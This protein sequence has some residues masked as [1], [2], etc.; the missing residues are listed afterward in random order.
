MIFLVCTTIN[1]R[2]N[3]HLILLWIQ[4]ESVLLIVIF[5]PNSFQV[6]ILFFLMISLLEMTGLLK[7]LRNEFII[8]VFSE[9]IASESLV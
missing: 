9:C 7:N 4:S 5:S 1:K 2:S 3:L 6:A 8:L